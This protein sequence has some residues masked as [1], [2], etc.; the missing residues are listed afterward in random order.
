MW[1]PVQVSQAR[2][3]RAGNLTQQQILS[4]GL[5]FPL[6]N[7][8]IAQIITAQEA[9]SEINRVFSVLNPNLQNP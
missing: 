4:Q 1:Q 3:F 8:D 9:A 5:K 2:P 7:D 6:Y